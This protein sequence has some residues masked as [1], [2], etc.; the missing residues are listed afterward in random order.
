[1]HPESAKLA[2]DKANART[3]NGAIE[4]YRAG[5]GSIPANV[6]VLVSGGYVKEAPVDPWGATPTRNYTIASGTVAPL[7]TD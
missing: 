7:G 1:M 5:V 6:A 4:V 3:L 2:A